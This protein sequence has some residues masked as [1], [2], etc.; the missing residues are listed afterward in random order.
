LGHAPV[1]CGLRPVGQHAGGVVR[2]GDRTPGT[3]HTSGRRVVTLLRTDKGDLSGDDP[4]R[5]RKVNG[6]IERHLAQR[7]SGDRRDR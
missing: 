1:R 3:R 7:P 6:N 2:R 5:M 4:A